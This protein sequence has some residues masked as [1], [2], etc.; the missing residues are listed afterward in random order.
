MNPIIGFYYLNLEYHL[1]EGHLVKVWYLFCVNKIPIFCG[2]FAARDTFNVMV[3][4]QRVVKNH[5]M[6]LCSTS[7]EETE[8]KVV[9]VMQQKGCTYTFSHCKHLCKG[10]SLCKLLILWITR[11]WKRLLLWEEENHAHS[12]AKVFFHFV[13]C[14]SVINCIL[15]ETFVA[16]MC[17][18][19]LISCDEWNIPKDRKYY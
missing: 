4:F 12:E 17:S 13:F 18:F 7:Q 11:P 8:K 14:H 5:K 19:F 9:N 10:F 6:N 3:N 2:W 1:G 15:E 16:F